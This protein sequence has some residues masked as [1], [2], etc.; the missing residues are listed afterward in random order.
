MIVDISAVF[1]SD[2]VFGTHSYRGLNV[3]SNSRRKD[4]P[5]VN[6]RTNH[7]VNKTQQQMQ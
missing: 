4:N 6:T 7:I 5:R 2:L 3:S 1:D